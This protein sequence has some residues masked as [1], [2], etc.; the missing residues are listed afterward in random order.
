MDR[1]K[2]LLSNSFIFTIANFGSKIITF[3]MVP[4]YTN[5]LNPNQYGSVDLITTTVN[6]LVPLL[7]MEIGQAIIRY[8]IENTDFRNR[9]KYY[10]V[11][12]NFREIYKIIEEL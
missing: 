9:K 8:S 12:T 3:L 1:Y 4:L 2:K 6:L 7:S 5:Y 10:K 11:L